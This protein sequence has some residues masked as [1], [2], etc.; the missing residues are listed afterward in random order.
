MIGLQNTVKDSIGTVWLRNF[1]DTGE[2]SSRAR[3]SRSKLLNGGTHISHR[4]VTDTD[5][6][7]SVDCRLSTE[8]RDAIDT[9]YRAGAE[10][11]ISFWE[12]SFIGLIAGLDIQRDGSATILFYFKEKLA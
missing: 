1:Q 4:G 5:R 10:L 7:F 3:I 6:D 11:M 2:Y 8:E 12:G 9:F